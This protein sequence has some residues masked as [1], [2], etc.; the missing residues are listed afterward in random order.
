MLV[1]SRLLELRSQK[2]YR[3]RI[4]ECDCVR[5]KTALIAILRT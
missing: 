2:T 5:K 4:S 1:D 3:L